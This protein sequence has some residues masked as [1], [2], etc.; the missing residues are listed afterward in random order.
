MIE[1]TVS[2]LENLATGEEDVDRVTADNV[3]IVGGD[4]CFF[5]VEA[6][7]TGILGLVR[8]REKLV[9]AYAAG[10][11]TSFSL[12]EESEMDWTALSP[13]MEDRIKAAFKDGSIGG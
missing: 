2:Y 4:L 1:F 11:W 3:E 8:M 7:H 13:E 5:K 10:V 6:E 9:C 12:I